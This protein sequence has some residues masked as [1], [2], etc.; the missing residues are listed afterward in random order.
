MNQVKLGAIISYISIF[1]NMIVAILY[2]PFF[3]RS[4]GASEYGLYNLIISFIGYITILDLSFGNTIAKNL[5]QNRI[6]GSKDDERKVL[7]NIAL[8]YFFASVV[9]TIFV[10]FIYVNIQ[11]IFGNSLNNQQIG[12]MKIMLIFLMIHIMISF[13]PGLF[14]GI[15]QAYEF[16]GIA[17]TILLARI[18][19]P[20]MISV[21]FLLS[22]SSSVVIILITL[23]VNFGCIV[24]GMILCKHKVNVSFDFT[25]VFK[26]KNLKR[27]KKINS[28]LLFI[29]LSIAVEQFTLNTGTII[30]GAVNGTVAVAVF[31]IAIQFVKI[32]QQFATSIYN[33]TFPGIAKMVVEGVE[34]STLLKQVI[35]I[36]KLQLIVLLLVLTGFVIFGRE[37]IIIWAGKTFEPAYIMTVILM[38]TITLQLTQLPA[39]S[40]I[41]AKN[42]QGF[43]LFV[44]IMTLLISMLF[45]IVFAP[46]YSG[47]GVSVAL[48]LISYISYTL[49]MN[50]YYHKRVK[51][52]MYLFWWEMF[53]YAFPILVTAITYFIIYH[54]IINKTGFDLLVF[55]LNIVI[56]ISVFSIVFCVFMLNKKEKRRIL[57]V[58]KIG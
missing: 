2:T 33:V 27:H 18:I 36:S 9:M 20:A 47:Y 22:G 48:G 37:F 58:L 19:L 54:Y 15:L 39:V 43:R 56:Y 51:L 38:T 14:N 44:L 57:K 32:Y 42:L 1:G 13:Y 3:I 21:P 41:Q 50:I 23:I 25:E 28:Y 29:F 55:S 40:V 53:K 24:T 4:L 31:V 6:M 52:N 30:I 16:F 46:S 8:L 11:V 5:S 34:P 45:A 35:K 26:L 12:E 17:K 7:G 10:Y 49:I